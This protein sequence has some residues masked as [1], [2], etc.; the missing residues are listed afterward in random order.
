[1][2]GLDEEGKM[3]AAASMAAAAAA[4]AGGDGGGDQVGGDKKKCCQTLPIT[5][6]PTRAPNRPTD[7]QASTFP[8]PPPL[9]LYLHK[10]L[11]RHCAKKY[12]SPFPLPPAV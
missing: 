1:M 6:L 3:D 10:S 5:T 8:F 2:E 12:A 9:L 4:A 11:P 7:D